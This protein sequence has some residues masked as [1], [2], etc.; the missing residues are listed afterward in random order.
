MKKIIDDLGGKSGF[1]GKPG[2]EGVNG[3]M[4]S[5][6]WTTPRDVFD[7]LNKAYGFTLDPCCT[8][9]SALCEKFY[10]IVENGLVQDWSKDVVFMNPPYGRGINKWVEKAY[11]ESEKGAVV[12]CLIPARTDTRYWWDFI[13]PHASDITFIK[14]R[15]KFGGGG[16]APFPSA[17]VEFNKRQLKTSINKNVCIINC[18]TIIDKE[19][20]NVFNERK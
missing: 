17:L 2:H 16:N 1:F 4:K 8:K 20:F 11:R 19:V 13:F 12:V 15:L 3:S 7:K 14:G 18:S 9:E 5:N 6:E 10:T